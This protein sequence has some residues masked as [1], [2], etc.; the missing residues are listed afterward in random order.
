MT[1]LPSCWGRT[2]T[3]QAGTDKPEHDQVAMDPAGPPK[4]STHASSHPVPTK[5]ARKAVKDNSW[6]MKKVKGEW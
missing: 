2:E 6:K 3:H 1:R 4:L 5:L